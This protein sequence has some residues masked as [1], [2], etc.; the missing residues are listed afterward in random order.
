MPPM[1]VIDADAARPHICR[2]MRARRVFEFPVEDP[3]C[4][5]QTIVV[6]WWPGR[7]YQVLTFRSDGN[8]AIE[9]L[10]RSLEQRVPFA[11]AKP[12]PEKFVTVVSK[13]DKDGLVFTLADYDPLADPLHEREYSNEQQAKAGHAEI[14]ELLA[15]GRL[16]LR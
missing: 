13:C 10:A 2:A 14:V 8:T 1:F 3:A 4:I 5:A 12:G 6:T 16:K 15:E 11:E 9:R 7:N